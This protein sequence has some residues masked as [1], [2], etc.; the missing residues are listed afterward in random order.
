MFTLKLAP[1]FVSSMPLPI[2][3]SALMVSIHTEITVIRPSTSEP[4]LVSSPSTSLANRLPSALVKPSTFTISIGQSRSR[5]AIT[6][7]SGGVKTEGQRRLGLSNGKNKAVCR[8]GGHR[9]A[10]V[11]N[12]AIIVLLVGLCAGCFGS[13]GE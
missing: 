7:L 1:T 4:A 3:S 2:P 9:A 11:F 6:E 5:H 8:G 13:D 10:Y 12:F